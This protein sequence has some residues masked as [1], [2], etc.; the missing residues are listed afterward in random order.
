MVSVTSVV[1]KGG[2]KI[3]LNRGWKTVPDYTVP[4][5][6]MIGRNNSTPTTSSTG[7]DTPIPITDGTL[8]DPG[9]NSFTGSL[10]GTNTTSNTS[11][12]KPGMSLSDNTGQNLLANGSSVSKVWTKTG[13]T[14]NF[15][16]TKPFGLWLYIKDST[17]LAKFKSSSTAL[18]IRIGSDASNYYYR[19]FTAS[20]LTTGW[21]WITSNTTLVS[22]LS[23]VGTPGG[24]LNTF[25]I[26]ITTNNATDTFAAPTN[27]TAE[28]VY[29]MARQWASTDTQKAFVSGYPSIDEVNMIVEIRGY[30]VSTEM[31]GFDFNSVALKNTDGTPIVSDID[32]FSPAESKSDTDEFSIILKNQLS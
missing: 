1:T 27:P 9:S 32:V 13:L 20:T 11:L 4:S 3:M 14:N 5:L 21:N 18:E 17:T 7:L 16:T 12:Y 19:T 30:I 15:V 31:N 22:A 6:F 10:G 26:V 28:V 23:T 2:D 25:I 24:T 29:D 8:I